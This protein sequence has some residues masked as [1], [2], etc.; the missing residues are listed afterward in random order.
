MAAPGRIS[1][2]VIIK[3]MGNLM[4][5]YGIRRNVCD[6]LDR[7]I[8]ELTPVSYTHLDVY[9]RQDVT[10]VAVYVECFIEIGVV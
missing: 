8:E 6:R 1:M 7:N 9:K 5:E 10:G 2:E 4:D 3:V